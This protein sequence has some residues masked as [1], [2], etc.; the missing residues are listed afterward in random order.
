MFEVPKS[1]VQIPKVA[2]TNLDGIFR[3][4]RNT[5]SLIT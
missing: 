4:S 3:N 1:G 2:T 5:F